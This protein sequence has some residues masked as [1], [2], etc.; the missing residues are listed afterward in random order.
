MPGAKKRELTTPDLVLLSLLAERPMHGY[1][2]NLELERR[3]VRDWAGISRPQV[4]YSLE[5][6]ARLGLI[7]T[8]DSDEP[9]A[10]PERSVFGTS[11]A[12]RAALGDALEREEWTEQREKPPF[13]TWIALSWQARPGVFERQIGRREKFLTQELEREQATLRAVQA[14]VGHRFHE[15]VW[16][17]SLTIQQLR[18]EL[19][20]LR[21]MAREV[22]RRKAARHA[23]YA[24]E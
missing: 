11:A 9:V 19:R 8:A 20:W 1:Q 10:G 15:A 7:K 14:E 18:T 4:Y 5:K 16:M 13:L 6:L 21:K 2:A 23:Q 3:Q 22:P 17:L 24:G 12:G